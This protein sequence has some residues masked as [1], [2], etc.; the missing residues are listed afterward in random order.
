MATVGAVSDGNHD[1]SSCGA[2][3]C[4][5]VGGDCS[6][7]GV[8]GGGDGYNCDDGGGVFYGDNSV[9]A[10]VICLHEIDSEGKNG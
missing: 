8:G 7:G 5:G 2:G 9:N 6:C 1:A 3:N 4:G 10:K